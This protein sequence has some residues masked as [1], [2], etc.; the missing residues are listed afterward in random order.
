MRDASVIPYAWGWHIG[1]DGF[2]KF[3]SP[4]S[5]IMPLINIPQ[6]V[7]GR[8]GMDWAFIQRITY[9]YPLLI[10]L[11]F[12]PIL[13]TKY[14]FPKNKFYLISVLIFSFNTYSLLLAGGEIFIALAYSLMPI[15]FVLFAYLARTCNDGESSRYKYPLITG[16][17]LAVQV[18]IDPRI[19]F[20]T[21]FAV[22]LYLALSIMYHVLSIKSS[23][24]K[25]LYTL[26]LILYTLA[27]P[28]GITVLLHAFWI[29]PSVLY[30]KN[31]VQALGSAYSTLGAVNYL[32]FARMENTISLLHPNWPENIFGK[33]YFMRPEFLLLPILAYASLLFIKGLKSSK[34]KKYILFFALLGIVGAFLAKGSNEP[35]GG[36]YLWL[37]KYFPGF[38]M[39]RDPAKWYPLVAISYSI[40]I[41]F[42]VWNI[43]ELLSSK[44]T[45]PPSAV[46]EGNC[47]REVQSSKAKF[48]I[49]NYIPNLFLILTTL[50][51]ILLIRPAIFGQLGGMFKTTFVPN[52]YVRLEKFLA[53]QPEYFRTLW[54]PSK[55]RFS[56]YSNNHPEIS[57]KVLFN[58]YDNEKLFEE[59]S[60]GKTENQLQQASIKYVIIPYDSEKEIFLDDR[61]Y[62]ETQYR[63]TVQEIRK[64]SWLKEVNCSIVRLL[65]CSNLPFGKIAVFEVSNPKDHFYFKNQESGIRNQEL[66][67]KYINPVKYEI[68]LRN[69]K[70]GD[71]LV[72]S[73]SF[74]SKWLARNHQ[75]SVFSS[76]FG[77]FNSFVLPVDGNYNLKIYYT[78][79]DYV[80]IGMAISGLTLALVIGAIF[81]LKKRK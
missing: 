27:I 11:I 79:Q 1:L 19:T 31:P 53:N 62:D 73:E 49:Q 77:I 64:I 72:F 17:V 28:L 12:S 44:F 10:L 2:A 26:H 80:N 81:Y 68:N 4:Y 51:L 29:I 78:L 22:M 6:V 42:S 58:L 14:F 20:V 15:I 60:K 41:P 38:I 46:A 7:F 50:Y 63:K 18:M 45:C 35:F 55:Q 21:M 23:R 65:N 30:G 52:D 48:K 13:L 43:Y 59:L 69:A 71:V 57:A 74:D 24:K 32:S 76:K 56:Y 61:K 25:I 47:R 5:W 54:V 33:V 67:Y 70:R 39:F 16:L 75:F 37:F 40:L 66:S 9:L 8:L 36:V 34:E 3:I